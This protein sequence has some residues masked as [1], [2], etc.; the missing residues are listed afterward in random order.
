MEV[1]IINDDGKYIL[2]FQVNNELL[3][4]VTNVNHSEAYNTRMYLIFMKFMKVL[5]SLF[6]VFIY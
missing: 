3:Q 2:A 1:T 5:F 4:R 6:S